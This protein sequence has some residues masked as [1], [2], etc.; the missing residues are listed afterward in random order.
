MHSA[1][2]RIKG[3]LWPRLSARLPW[4]L[5]VSYSQFGEDAILRHLTRTWPA[6]TYV[7]IGAYHPIV[8][9]NTYGLYCRGWRGLT[10]DANP[11]TAE[12]FAAFRPADRHEVCAVVTDPALT[13]IAYYRF[14]D[15]LYNTISDEFAAEVSQSGSSP[16]LE[17]RVMRAATISRLLDGTGLLTVDVLSVDVEGMDTAILHSWPWDRILPRVIIAESHGTQPADIRDSD[18]HA[19][20]GPRGYSVVGCCGPSVL[21]QLVPSNA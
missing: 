16:L 12:E 18:I 8:L 1:V 3:A 10:I 17:R 6:G 14:A 4:N 19:L 15:P 13:E 9:S 2:K 5:A 11:D 20:I 21:W 7:D